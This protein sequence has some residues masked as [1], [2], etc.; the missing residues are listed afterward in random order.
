MA[1]D[2]LPTMAR[3]VM[4]HCPIFV[5]GKWAQVPN[6]GHTCEGQRQEQMEGCYVI[7]DI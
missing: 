1:C 4:L 7:F 3:K 5:T 6:P 2:I